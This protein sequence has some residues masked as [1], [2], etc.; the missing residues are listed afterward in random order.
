MKRVLYF[1]PALLF[2]AGCKKYPD[3]EKGIHFRFVMDRLCRDWKLRS[4]K[5]LN[6]SSLPYVQADELTFEDNGQLT[7]GSPTIMGSSMYTGTALILGGWDFTDSK[8][9]GIVMTESQSSEQHYFTIQQL[10]PQEL[11]LRNDTA[12]FFFVRK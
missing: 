11:K 9:S 1:I 7:G 5:D 2:I 6:G 3:D 8:K 12:D 10:D 4:V